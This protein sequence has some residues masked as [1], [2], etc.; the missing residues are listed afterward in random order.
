MSTVLEPIAAPALDP[1]EAIPTLEEEPSA[2]PLLGPVRERLHKYGWRQGTIGSPSSSNCLLGAAY[3]SRGDQ[4][5]VDYE[6]PLD[7]ISIDVFGLPSNQVVTLNDHVETNE[8]VISLFLD[9]L[10]SGMDPKEAWALWQTER[11]PSDGRI[12]F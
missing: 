1:L 11:P 9:R 2:R 3:F 12:P 7:Q 4:A 5:L 10:E 6:N 8:A